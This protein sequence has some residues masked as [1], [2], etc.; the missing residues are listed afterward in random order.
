MAADLGPP[1]LLAAAA[2]DELKL[3]VG[4]MIAG[5]GR[6]PLD[7]VTPMGLDSIRSGNSPTGDLPVD[8]RVVRDEGGSA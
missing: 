2:V 6:R 7:G 8:D 5:R 1:G 3:A 4:P